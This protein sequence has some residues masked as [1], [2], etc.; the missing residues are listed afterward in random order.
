MPSS[1]RIAMT[2]ASG[3]LGTSLQTLLHA[4]GHSV[5]PLVRKREQ[6][7]VFWDPEGGSL[8]SRELEGVDAV[9]H[10]AGEN[11]GGGAWTA[12]RKARILDSR[13]KGTRLLCQALVK[14]GRPPK[15]LISASAIGYY[16]DRGEELLE[17]SSAPGEDFLA[18][19]CRAWEE[20][21]AGAEEVGIRV[22]KLRIGIVLDSRGGALARM[23]LPFRLGLG[24]P[25][26]TG[27]QWMS[28]IDRDDLLRIFSFAL[29]RKSLRGPVNAVSPHAVP[30]GE[31]ARTL[32]RVLHRPAVIPLPSWAVRGAFGEM[33]QS[34]LLSSAHVKPGCLT[35]ADFSFQFSELYD[36]LMARTE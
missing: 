27:R 18:R 36:S 20:E 1:L 25:V 22:V 12:E 34:L 3:L 32:G 26:G 15:T 7:G 19:V 10:L 5:I 28:W 24:G 30:Q 13:V 6:A 31:F 33:G 21:T 16:G 14:M 2:G 4:E 35:D 29:E 11:V 23:L 8:D 17:E 9:I